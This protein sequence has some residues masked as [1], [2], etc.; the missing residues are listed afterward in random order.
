M[1]WEM[2]DRAWEILSEEMRNP[3]PPPR[4]KPT[5]FCCGTCGQRIIA[6]DALG[7]YVRDKCGCEPWW[8]IRYDPGF[9]A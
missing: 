1:T 3:S 5:S 9:F 6:Q 2:S 7:G 4:E 8:G